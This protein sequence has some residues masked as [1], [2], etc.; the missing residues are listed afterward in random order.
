MRFQ[1]FLPNKSEMM[2]TRH[3]GSAQMCIITLTAVLKHSETCY[4]FLYYMEKEGLYLTM[5][6]IAK[7]I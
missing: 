6:L 5:L 4:A 1:F 7:I 3:C 2:I